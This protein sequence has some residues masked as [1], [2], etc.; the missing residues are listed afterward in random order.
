MLHP[1][2]IFPMTHRIIFGLLCVAA[3][4]MLYGASNAQA[5]EQAYGRAWGH[6]RNTQDWDKF[7]HYPYVYYAQNFKPIDYYKSSDNLY[8]RY[9]PE[10]QIPVYNKQW[11]NYYPKPRKYYRGAHFNLDVF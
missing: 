6:S 5:Q 3:L 4:L 8:N 9:P 11:Q 7:Y 10:M 1:G 2:G